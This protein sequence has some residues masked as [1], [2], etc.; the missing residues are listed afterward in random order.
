MFKT[1]LTNNLTYMRELAGGLSHQLQYVNALL[2]SFL[3]SGRPRYAWKTWTWTT[4]CQI[5]HNRI[6]FLARDAFLVTITGA[7]S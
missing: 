7:S 3:Y 1:W 4:Y 5:L 6:S 2:S